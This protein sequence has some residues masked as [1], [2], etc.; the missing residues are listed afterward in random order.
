MYYRVAIRRPGN[1]QGRASIWRWESTVLSSLQTLFHFLRLYHTLPQDHLRVFFSCECA[2]LEEQLVREN[3]GFGSQSV[4]ATRFFQKRLIRL[5]EAPQGMSGD[6][7]AKRQE[8]APIAVSA[9][10]QNENGAASSIPGREC[11]CRFSENWLAIEAGPGADHDIPY[12]FALPA[13]LP[14]VLAWV[15]L[16]ASVQRRELELQAYIYQREK[17]CNYIVFSI[18]RTTWQRLK[19]FSV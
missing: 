4:T 9:R 17:N 8:G 16:L 18:R 6:E 5:P 12:H 19:D 10:V 3:Q 7:A 2:S 13:S 11:A 1:Q 14:Q 15:R